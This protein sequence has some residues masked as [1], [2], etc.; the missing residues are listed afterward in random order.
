MVPLSVLEVELWA[1]HAE[2]RDFWRANQ[3]H[4]EDTI[5]GTGQLRGRA[6]IPSQQQGRLLPSWFCGLFRAN[7]VIHVRFRPPQISISFGSTKI[8]VCV[9]VCV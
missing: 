7:C 4:H 9:C 3:P 1:E 5:G 8:G 6:G 2:L